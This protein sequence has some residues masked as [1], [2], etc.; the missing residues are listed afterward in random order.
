MADESAK[1][2]TETR[3]RVEFTIDS[4]DGGHYRLVLVTVSSERHGLIETTNEVTADLLKDC[5]EYL[6]DK[7]GQE[8]PEYYRYQLERAYHCLETFRDGSE[9]DDLILTWLAKSIKNENP[10]SSWLRA[11]LALGQSTSSAM[12]MDTSD[13]KSGQKPKGKGS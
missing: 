11:I 12:T 13:S 9:A 6:A 8:N 1:A 5:A 2:S 10:T 4:T 3:Q 7:S